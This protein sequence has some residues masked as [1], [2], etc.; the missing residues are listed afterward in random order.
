MIPR[1]LLVALL[2][3]ATAG[4]AL[5]AV[6]DQAEDESESPPLGQELS[7]AVQ[8]TDAEA[9]GEVSDGV[10]EARLQRANESDREAILRERADELDRRAD[11]VDRQ[12]DALESANGSVDP[13]DPANDSFVAGARAS[14]VL[15]HL[16][17]IRQ[18]ANLTE[19]RAA[20]SELDVP[21]V[22]RVRDRTDELGDREAAGAARSAAFVPPGLRADGPASAAG[23]G[24]NGRT[25]PDTPADANRNRS[26]ANGGGPPADTPAGGADDRSN[27]DGRE[28]ARGNGNAGGGGNA[29]G[30]ED[31]GEN[32]NADGNENEN[33]DGNDGSNGADER[34]GNGGDRGASNGDGRS[35]AADGAGEPP[36]AADGPEADDTGAP[37]ADQD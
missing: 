19:R 25:G 29:D 16:A 2:L 37:A 35:N 23:D 31:A 17:S 13:A 27:G 11:R 20:E 30:N 18:S 14:A 34:R 8:S 5:P 28:N 15:A 32:G 4:L 24:R 7:A 26:A 1:I 10:F 12:L 6:A 22:T 36:G 33:A 3:A 21:G 9:S